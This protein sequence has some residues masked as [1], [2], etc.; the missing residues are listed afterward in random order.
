MLET[1]V[2]RVGVL[3][4]AFRNDDGAFRNDDGPASTDW[5]FEGLRMMTVGGDALDPGPAAT[6]QMRSAATA[7][8]RGMALRDPSAVR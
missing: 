7:S 6:D 1:L 8:A 5:S 2:S 4:N 3:L